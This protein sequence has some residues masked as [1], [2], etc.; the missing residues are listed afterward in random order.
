MAARKEHYMPTTLLDSQLATLEP[1]Q[2]DE[3]GLVLDI[4]QPPAQL[5]QQILRT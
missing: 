3:A 4:A 1:L 5:V 2:D